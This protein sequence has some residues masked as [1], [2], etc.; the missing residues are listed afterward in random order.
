MIEKNQRHAFEE[1]IVNMT[2][3][4]KYINE[5]LFYGITIYC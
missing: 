4:T 1:A 3:N 2:S 5:Y